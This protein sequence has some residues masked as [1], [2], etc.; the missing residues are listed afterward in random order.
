MAS[1]WISCRGELSGGAIAHL[2]YAGIYR[3]A[4]EDRGFAPQEPVRHYLSIEA[5]DP[6]DALLIA[7]GA[8]AVAGAGAHDLRAGD[9]PPEPA[10]HRP[11]K[12][13][14]PKE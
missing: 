11:E 1:Y 4:S 6:E 3:C 12:A 14:Y 9:S 13:T 2:R 8:L 10:G 5:R 7:R